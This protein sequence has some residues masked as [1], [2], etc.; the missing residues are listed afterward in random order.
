MD[1]IDPALDLFIDRLIA[2]SILSAD[3]RQAVRALPTTRV[4][5]RAKQD[6]V[7]IDEEVKHSCLVVRGLVGRFGQTSDGTRQ[8]TAFHVAGDMADLHSA[9][10]PIGIGGMTALCETTILRISHAAI[11][12]VAAAHPAIAEA[13]WR[14]C[15]VD[16]AIL[17]QW[18]VN[19]GRRDTRTRL[20]HLFCEMAVR[21]GRSGPPLLDYAFPVSQEQLADA[22]AITGVHVNRSLR[23]C[24]RTG[25]SPSAAA[26]SG[27]AIGIGWLTKA[28]SAAPI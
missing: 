8:I 28:S 11:R 19:I 20:A 27:S 12:G 14:D 26:A 4:E 7:G 22:T 18:V 16:A 6:F 23:G 5:L 3:E 17:M 24:V 25:S 10:R 2:R 21:L 9:V 15:M 13:F 1:R